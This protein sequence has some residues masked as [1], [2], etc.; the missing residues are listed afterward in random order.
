MKFRQQAANDA[1][2]E[3]LAETGRAVE[4]LES[5]AKEMPLEA[6]VHVIVAAS[7]LRY[8]GLATAI[9]TASNIDQQYQAMVLGAGVAMQHS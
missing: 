7:K 2:K 6:R 5:K 4:A 8:E 1:Y 9:L 3:I